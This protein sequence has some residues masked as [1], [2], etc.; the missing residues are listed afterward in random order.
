LTLDY[1]FDKSLRLLNSG[2]FKAVFDGASAKAH[3]QHFLILAKSNGTSTP[4]LGLVIAKKNIRLAVNRNKVKRIIRETFR[5]QQHQLG[6]IDAI[7]LARRGMDQL[8]RAE[9]EKLLVKQWQRL[10]KKLASQDSQ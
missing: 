3:Q 4:R 7:V 6:G 1:Q 10:A 5:H 8:D 9:L 2:D